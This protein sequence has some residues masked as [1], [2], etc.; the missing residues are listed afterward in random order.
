MKKL[1]I[2]GFIFL[3]IIS[4]FISCQNSAGTDQSDGNLST[5]QE[6]DNGTP[7]INFAVDL[8]DFGDISQ[9]EKVSYTFAYSNDGDANLII[10]S[11]R[12]GCGCTVPKWNK[13]PLPPGEKGYIEVVFDSSGRSGRQIKSVTVKSNGNPSVKTLKIQANIVEPSSN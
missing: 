12:A 13:N 4:G 3:F 10:Q 9:G 7:I 2:F 8:Y 1:F 6:S 5:D 11:A